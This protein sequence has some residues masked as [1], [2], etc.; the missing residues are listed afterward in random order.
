VDKFGAAFAVAGEE[1]E[2]AADQETL[3]LL[4][5][6]GVIPALKKRGRNSKGHKE[7]EERFHHDF[8]G[9]DFTVR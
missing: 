1:Q 3:I 2:K 6:F 9:V 5:R 4:Q 8:D 7:V